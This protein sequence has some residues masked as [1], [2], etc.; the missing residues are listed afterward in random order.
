MRMETIIK[1]LLEPWRAEIPPPFLVNV[2]FHLRSSEGLAKG[3]RRNQVRYVG[4]AKAKCV[5]ATGLEM[6]AL[7]GVLKSEPTGADGGRKDERAHCRAHGRREGSGGQT[8][9]AT[10]GTAVGG[11]CQHRGPHPIGVSLE[12]EDTQRAGILADD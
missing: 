1:A 8:R 2:C 11:L 10:G 9:A 6:S 4:P 12:A 7:C 3:P 5:V